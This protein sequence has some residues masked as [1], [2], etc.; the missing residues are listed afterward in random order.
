MDIYVIIAAIGVVAVGLLV[1]IGL[2]L[3]DRRLSHEGKETYSKPTLWG[4]LFLLAATI[5]ALYMLGV[6]E[7]TATI[8]LVVFIAAIAVFLKLITC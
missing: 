6:I 5:V 8:A 4:T 7:R 1:F 3:I 2:A